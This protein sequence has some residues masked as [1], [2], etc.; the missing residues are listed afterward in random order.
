MWTLAKSKIKALARLDS[1]AVSRPDL[2]MCT[3]LLPLDMV[4]PLRTHAP[5][6]LCVLISFSSK[7]TN[8]DC[9]QVDTKGLILTHPIK[10][11]VSKYSH[12]LRD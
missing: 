3:L 4:I 10:S 1:S 6:S 5:V 2:Q 7:D 9:I 11:P 8:Q 12:I